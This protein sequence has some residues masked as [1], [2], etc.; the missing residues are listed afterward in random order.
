MKIFDETRNSNVRRMIDVIKKIAGFDIAVLIRGETGAGKETIASFIHGLSARRAEKMVRFNCAAIT[1]SIVE[2]E[3][4]GY[5]KG[6]FT[7]ANDTRAGLVEHAN[8]GT[9]FLDE[10]GDMGAQVQAKILRVADGLSFTRVGGREQIVSNVRLIAATHM[11]LKKMVKRGSFREDLYHRLAG[12]VIQVPALRERREDIPELAE[13]MRKTFEKKFEMNVVGF[14]LDCMTAMCTYDW[15]GNIRE[16]KQKIS[17]AIV[18]AG[19]G[20]LIEKR[21]VF[22]NESEDENSPADFNLERVEREMILKALERSAW[23]QQDA[24][25]HLGVSPRVLNYKIRQH[26]ITHPTWRANGGERAG[27]NGQ[28]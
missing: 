24:A 13:M 12:V 2:S 20:N 4:F 5:E 1:D 16:L 7:G 3:L 19:A 25:P 23:V 10:I 8:R 11:N 14:D 17:T 18:L 22:D 26:G 27:E 21:H 9:L 6:A 28:G 15:P